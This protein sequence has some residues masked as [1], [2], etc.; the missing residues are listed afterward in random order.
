MKS[1]ISLW[2]VVALMAVSLFAGMEIKQL[3]SGDNVI[4]QA[5]KFREVLSLTQ[6]YYVKEVD[7]QKL[8]ESA[9]EGLLEK[10]DPH[11]VYIEPKAFQQ[12]AEEFRGNFEGIGVTFTLRNDSILVVDTFGGGPSAKVGIQTN[13][14]IVRIGDS[15]SIGWTNDQVK[16]HL[17]GPKGTKVRVGIHRPGTKEILDFEIVRDVIAITSVDIAMMVTDD[18]GYIS[19]NK[20]SEQ[21]AAE[22][23]RSLK[24]LK[25]QGMKRLILDL[26]L[27][28]GGLLEQAFEMA[29]LFLDGGSKDAP[30]KIVYTKARLPEFNEAYYA[31][32]GQA[33]ERLPIII[34][35]SNYSASASEIVAGAIQD[36]D[37]GLIVG[38]TSF[39]KGLVQRQWTLKDGSALR[40]TIARYYTPSGRLIQRD[41]EGK[42]RSEYEKEAFGRKEQEGDNLEHKAESDSSRPIFHTHGGR[43]VFGGGGITPDYVIK[44]PQLT[45]LTQSILRRGLYDQYVTTYLDGTGLSVRSEYGKDWKKFRSSFLIT[46]QMLAGFKTYLKNHDVKIDEK[47]FEKDITF[48]KTRLKATVARNFWGNEGWY[49]LMLQV[50]AQYQKALS[51]FPEAEKIAKLN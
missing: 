3:I 45:E 15:T 47:E 28:P 13:D 14:R 16:A 2:T 34:L 41:Y 22:M 1:K 48:T 10:L 12:V 30:H 5:D 44:N 11:S 39:G 8:T 20:F 9:V 40:L 36:W 27:N 24:K 7:P 33:Y 51:L 29:D 50:D 46:D 25:E 31:K 37:R 21:T 23:E 43:I 6:K 17:R 26:R 49:P 19:V 38:E 18:V 42:D 4:D 35:I 32:D